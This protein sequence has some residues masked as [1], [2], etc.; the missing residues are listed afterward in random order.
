MRATLLAINGLKANVK[1]NE[2]KEL[3]KKTLWSLF[4]DKVQ[5]PQD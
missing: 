1:Q 5:L 3:F 2:T 4:M